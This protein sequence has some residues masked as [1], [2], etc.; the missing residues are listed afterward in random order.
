MQESTAIYYI[1]SVSIISTSKYIHTRKRTASTFQPK[2]PRQERHS[3]RQNNEGMPPR[4]A[5]TSK[6]R[7]KRSSKTTGMP[8]PTAERFSEIMPCWSTICIKIVHFQHVKAS[9]WWKSWFSFAADLCFS[10]SALTSESMYPHIS[11]SGLLSRLKSNLSS[12]STS[13]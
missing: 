9:N 11:W 13:W 7:C 12:N 10:I 1:H 2:G 3:P 8:R 4:Q 6:S 5:P